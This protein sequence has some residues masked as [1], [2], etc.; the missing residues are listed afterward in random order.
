MTNSGNFKPLKFWCQMV[1][2]TVYDDSL[3][4]YEL[5]NKVVFKLNELGQYYNELSEQLSNLGGTVSAEVEKQLQEMI[6]NGELE[7]LINNTLLADK[8]D[9]IAPK[10]NDIDLMPVINRVSGRTYGLGAIQGVCVLDNGNIVASYSYDTE[11]GT[12]AQI[13]EYNID[14]TSPTI[15]KSATLPIGHCAGLS[16]NP[17]NNMIYTP[18][19]YTQQ[20]VYNT[21]VILINADTFAISQTITVNGVSGN[22]LL[23]CAY[24]RKRNS[25]AVMD[26]NFNMYEYDSTLTTGTAI[27]FTVPV[28]ERGVDYWVGQTCA[29]DDKY[30]YLSFYQPA[31]IY[32]IDYSGNLVMVYN[33]P[34]YAGNLPTHEI[35]GLDFN[36]DNGN[37][38]IAN[39][40]FMCNRLLNESSIL[41]GNLQKNGVKNARLRTGQGDPQATQNFYVNPAATNLYAD[42]SQDYPFTDLNQACRHAMCPEYVTITINCSLG[43]YNPLAVSGINKG[44]VITTSQVGVNIPGISITNCLKFILQGI[45]VT[46]FAPGSSNYAINCVRSNVELHSVTCNFGDKNIPTPFNAETNSILTLGNNL[47]A[48]ANRKLT[49]IARSQVNVDPKYDKQLIVLADNWS[50][51]NAGKW[52]GVAP[53]VYSANGFS[54][55]VRVIYNNNMA[56]IRAALTRPDTNSKPSVTYNDKNYY[57]FDIATYTGNLFSMETISPINR[58]AGMI[59]GTA[60]LECQRTSHGTGSTDYWWYSNTFM[61]IYDGTTTTFYIRINNSNWEDIIDLQ[62][63]SIEQSIWIPFE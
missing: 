13:I 7:D 18:M 43:N 15:V 37:V 51:Y 50:S 36:R 54:G 14:G 39:N 44:I 49:R 8:V 24:N 62:A 17:N 58:T 2:P 1:L 10:S 34:L 32:C 60:W 22:G 31:V 26:N 4:F 16:Y 20:G 19:L 63:I 29:T 53:T 52:Q 57:Y 59:A 9:K 3:S 12:N 6:D 42:G 5:L 40:S 35:E 41:Q 61:I 11:N 25:F 46:D 27:P 33:M 55:N 48:P 30:I 45:T 38:Y 56:M 23:G 21:N 28:N 47:W